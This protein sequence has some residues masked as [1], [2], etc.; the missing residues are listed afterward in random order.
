MIVLYSIAHS[1]AFLRISVFLILAEPSKSNLSV[2][3][4]IPYIIMS[5]LNFCHPIKSG[6][7]HSL[8][9]VHLIERVTKMPANLLTD[10]ILDCVL[11][12]F[13]KAVNFIHPWRNNAKE[14]SRLRSR[15][16]PWWLWSLLPH[17]IPV[18]SFTGK[19]NVLSIPPAVVALLCVISFHEVPPLFS[20][21]I[22]LVSDEP[23]VPFSVLEKSICTK[24]CCLQLHVGLGSQKLTFLIFVLR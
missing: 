19:E 23:I 10:N 6:V 5:P 3:T 22:V 18:I 16:L 17:R 1:Y 13:K 7:N 20:A 8:I 11:G 9:D 15:F 12:L 21:C 4:L 2:L 24:R 14:R